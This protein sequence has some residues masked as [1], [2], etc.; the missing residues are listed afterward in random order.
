MGSQA[1]QG[2]SG[3]HVFHTTLA[4]KKNVGNTLRF[5]LM[6]LLSKTKIQTKKKKKKKTLFDISGKIV[7]FVSVRS[8][9]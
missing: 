9:Q 2:L 7:A 4:K 6:V 5:D 8:A 3:K 1:E